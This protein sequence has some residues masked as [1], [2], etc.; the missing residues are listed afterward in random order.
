MA[1]RV[2]V[3]NTDDVDAD[4]DDDAGPCENIVVLRRLIGVLEKT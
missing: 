1:A 2:R 3:P 4:R